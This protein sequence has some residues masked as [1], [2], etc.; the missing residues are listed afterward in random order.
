MNYFWRVFLLLT[1]TLEQ[2]QPLLKMFCFDNYKY[3]ILSPLGGKPWI[4]DKGNDLILGNVLRWPPRSWLRWE[5][6]FLHQWI[7]PILIEKGP[8]RDICK[9]TSFPQ[10]L[11]C[12]SEE[13]NIQW[14]LIL[15]NVCSDRKRRLARFHLSQK[16]V[17]NGGNSILPLFNIFVCHF[18]M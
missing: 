3:D 1:P 5:D 7:L 13:G 12:G 4:A 16:R 6:V 14:P 8:L 11:G 2:A 10:L 15:G 18:S 9:G 17:V